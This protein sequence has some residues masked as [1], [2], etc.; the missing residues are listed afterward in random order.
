MFCPQKHKKN[1]SLTLSFIISFLCDRVFE[2]KYHAQRL[3]WCY[4]YDNK[5]RKT[6]AYM[7]F[8][9]VGDMRELKC[10]TRG[11]CIASS[12]ELETDSTAN[13]TSFGWQDRPTGGVCLELSKLPPSYI[14]I[15]SGHSRVEMNRVSRNDRGHYRHHQCSRFSINISVC[16]RAASSS[17]L[18]PDLFSFSARSALQQQG[19]GSHIW[20]YGHAAEMRAHKHQQTHMIDE[21]DPAAVAKWPYTA[22]HEWE[23]RISKVTNEIIWPKL[24]EKLQ[25]I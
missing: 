14:F 22:S 7:I 3:H 16:P 15:S 5:N 23:E 9:K 24:E 25:H 21:R 6:R 12:S 19:I 1:N 8:L 17:S 10:F 18:R 4:F 2:T 20:H 11:R 13:V